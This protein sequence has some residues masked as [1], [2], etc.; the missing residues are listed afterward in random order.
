MGN[1]ILY[2]MGPGKAESYAKSVIEY[3]PIKNHELSEELTDFIKHLISSYKY[4]EWIVINALKHKIGIHHGLVPKYIQKEIINFFNSGALDVLVSTTTITEGVNTSAKNLLVLNAKKGDKDL[5]TFDAKNIAG[6]AGRFLHHYSGRVLIFDKKFQEIIEGSDNE[7][8]HKNFDPLAMK[9]EIDYF[10][11]EEIF[12][13]KEDIF[14]RKRIVEKQMERGIPD[15][16]MSMFRVISHSDKIT[17]YDIIA[18]LSSLELQQIRLLIQ[19]IHR[20]LTIDYNGFK[21]VLKIIKPI[22][23]NAN[24][25]FLIENESYLR[26]GINAGKSYPT[27]VYILSAYLAEGFAGSVSYN[28]GRTHP[29]GRKFTID[30]AVRDSS[31]FIFSTLKYQLVKYLGVFNL[32]YKYYLSVKQNKN[33][34]DIVGIDRLLLKLEYNAISDKGI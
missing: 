25:S 34:D 17:V 11:T 12:L 33:L 10:I 30:E 22:V 9:N 27:L 23:T 7:I 3:S 13:S 2:T 18:D 14:N 28:L 8:K 32:M 16:I 26:N 24:L 15:E 4:N 21:V 6:R 31:K 29:S 19:S 1:A 5:K 20:N